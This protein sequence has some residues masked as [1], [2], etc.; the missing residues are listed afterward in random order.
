MFF[1]AIVVIFAQRDKGFTQSD[2]IYA[3]AEEIHILWW[4]V[5]R[6]AGAKTLSGKPSI[7]TVRREEW[8]TPCSSSA[9]CALRNLRLESRLLLNYSTVLAQGLFFS[10]PSTT[11][12]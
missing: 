2:L 7:N 12:L 5:F 9:K 8:R 11:V 4:N 10:K 1:W 6:G 3:H